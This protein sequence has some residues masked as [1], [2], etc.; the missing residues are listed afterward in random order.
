MLLVCRVCG[1]SGDFAVYRAREM[2]Y[3]TREAFDYFQC[4]ECGCLQIREIPEDIGRYYP[5]NYYSKNVSHEQL[6]Q[7]RRVR[8]FI[9]SLKHYLSNPG[10]SRARLK[11]K[12]LS[13]IPSLGMQRDDW[14][15]DVGC[16][17][18]RLPYIMKEAGFRNVYGADPFIDRELVY[19]NGLTIYKKSIDQMA[20]D[21]AW[22]FIMF[23]HSFEHVPNPLEVLTQAKTM[24][25][26]SGRLVIR[27]PVVGY[28]WEKY[29]VDWYQLDAPRHLF[30]HSKESMRALADAAGLAIDKIQYDS[31][32]SQFLISE[33]YQKGIPLIQEVPKPRGLAYLR[34]KLRKRKF[35]K[36][37]RLL[38][39]TMNGDQAVFVLSRS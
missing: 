39:E 28:A 5:D 4:A 2:F 20:G 30:L 23:H 36:M 18:G 8:G 17:A 24:L 13:V 10:K 7:E 21:P 11:D 25:K 38:N 33:N 14:I 9:R 32:M 19:A 16:G 22:D 3:G 35:R 6:V 27:I 12:D 15:L 1:S 34:E 37:S 29:G 26:D 31:T